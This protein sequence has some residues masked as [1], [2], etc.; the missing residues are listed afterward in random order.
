MAINRADQCRAWNAD[1]Q[2]QRLAGQ[3]R[4]KQFTS[5]HQS[6]AALAGYRAFSLRFRA[7]NGGPQLFPRDAAKYLSPADIRLFGQSLPPPLQAVILAAWTSGKPWG[8]EYWL[9]PPAVEPS[10]PDGTL[11]GAPD[12]H[13]WSDF[14]PGWRLCEGCW[15]V[16]VCPL[17][18]PDWWADRVIARLSHALCGA[19]EGRCTMAS[20]R[21][22]PVLTPAVLRAVTANVRRIFDEWGAAERRH[23][24]SADLTALQTAYDQANAAYREARDR[25]AREGVP[26]DDA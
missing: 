10:L 14:A 4:A 19:M 13:E 21:L 1:H 5:E 18:Q 22:P 26:L 24:S 2:H 20:I 12:A 3:A 25:A 15:L 16:A 17:C 11:F 9:L 7:G 6:H 23:A 8:V